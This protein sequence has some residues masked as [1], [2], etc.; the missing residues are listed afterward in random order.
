MISA[1]PKWRTAS[2]NDTYI[3]HNSSSQDSLYIVYNCGFN[4]VLKNNLN[5]LWVQTEGTYYTV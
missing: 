5:S 2:L 3:K 1:N 4:T